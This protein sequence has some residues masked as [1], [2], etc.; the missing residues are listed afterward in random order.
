MKYIC[1]NANAP[2]KN[3]EWLK[4]KY[5]QEGMFINQIAAECGHHP[6][7]IKRW[8]DKFGIKTVFRVSPKKLGCHTVG[9]ERGDGRGYVVVTA[10]DHPSSNSSGKVFKH[11]L[12]AEEMLGRPLLPEEV[13]HHI[14]GD[15]ADNRPEN[16]MVFGSKI[17]HILYHRKIR[18]FLKTRLQEVASE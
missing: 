10:P 4:Q 14:N 3:K 18:R 1:K 9:R 11:R 17:E 15:R 7:T 16:L 6:G 8:M 12:V 2:Y 5:E 13:V